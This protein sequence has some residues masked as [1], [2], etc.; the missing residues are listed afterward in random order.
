EAGVRDSG[1]SGR[2]GPDG[3]G[4]CGSDECGSHRAGCVFH[5]E[6]FARQL[7]RLRMANSAARCGTPAQVAEL[8]DALP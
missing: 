8:V 5:D 4:R 1:G 6:A 3:A 2:C 7:I